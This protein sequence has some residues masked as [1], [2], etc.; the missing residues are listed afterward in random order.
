VPVGARDLRTNPRT[1]EDW[2]Q[3]LVHPNAQA[4]L[5]IRHKWWLLSRLLGH[6]LWALGRGMTEK[7]LIDRATD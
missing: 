6:P 5:L 7:I 3:G 2:E 4:S 1:V